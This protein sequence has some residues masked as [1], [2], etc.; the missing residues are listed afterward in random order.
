VHDLPPSLTAHASYLLSKA[1]KSARSRVAADLAADDLRLWHPA[2]LA[3]LADFGPHAQ[4]E[5][6]ARL[7][8]DASDVV[9][10]LDE[11]D[12]RGWTE[13]TRDPAD[14]RRHRVDITAAGRLALSGILAATSRVDDELLKPLSPRQ[15]EQFRRLL[16]KIADA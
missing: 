3:A 2:I 15:R 14:R 1:G 8:L 12:A 11:L 5:L 13:R 4:R 10:A 7:N 9:K 6:A 16:R